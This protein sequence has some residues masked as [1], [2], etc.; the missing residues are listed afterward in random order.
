[1]VIMQQKEVKKLLCIIVFKGRFEE[2]QLLLLV[3][4]ELV[5][6]VHELKKKVEKNAS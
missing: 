2:N 1:M 3:L 5:C 4:N 6:V